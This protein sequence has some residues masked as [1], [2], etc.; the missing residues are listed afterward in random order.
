MISRIQDYPKYESI[1]DRLTVINCN[2]AEIEK[3]PQHIAFPNLSQKPKSQKFI[4]K[5]KD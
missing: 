4:S 2:F 1:K 3:I 5:G